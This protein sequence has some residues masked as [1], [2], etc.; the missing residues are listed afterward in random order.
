LLEDAGFRIMVFPIKVSEKLE[1]NLNP[2]EQII[3]IAVRKS[4]AAENELKSLKSKDFLLLT[5]DTMVVLDDQP[6]GK[7]ADKKE[8]ELM[9][10]RLSGRSHEVKTAV[11]LYESSTQRRISQ[12]ETTRVFFRKIA[13]QEILDYIATGEPM[14]KAGSYAIQGLGGK[15]VQKFEGD[16]NNVVGLPMDLVKKILQENEW[17][18]K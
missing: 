3:A 16:Y 12:I 4:L 14:D 17:M 9:L 8:A 11:C 15:F 18:K 2:D 7:P 13:P 6:L 5:A 10:T 1:K